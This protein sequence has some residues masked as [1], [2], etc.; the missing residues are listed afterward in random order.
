MKKTLE[1]ELSNI[2]ESKKHPTWLE[3]AIIGAEWQKDNYNINALDFEIDSLKR[4]IKVLKHQ[5]EKSYTEKEV[6]K[7][8]NDFSFDWNYNYRGELNTKEYLVEWFNKNKKK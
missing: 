6:Y 2:L 5:Q 3:I 7:L 8:I 4:Q 1:E